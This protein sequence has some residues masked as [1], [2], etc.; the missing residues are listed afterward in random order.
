MSRSRVLGNIGDQTATLGNVLKGDGSDFKSLTIFNSTTTA[1]SKT[2]V[3]FE[4][5]T[6]TSNNYVELT[7]PSTPQ[8]GWQVGIGI[9][10]FSSNTKVMRNGTSIMGIAEDLLLDMSNSSITMVYTGASVGWKI[11]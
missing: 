10:A 11:Y 9:G 1:T 6:V 7:L 2:L 4:Y 8:E 3:N 5:C